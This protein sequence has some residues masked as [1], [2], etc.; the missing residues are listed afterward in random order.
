MQDYY[1]LGVNVFCA[2]VIEASVPAPQRCQSHVRER[3]ALTA[4]WKHTPALS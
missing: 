1:A 4:L 3:A 2:I